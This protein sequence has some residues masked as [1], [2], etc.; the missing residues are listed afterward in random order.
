MTEI[1]PGL[2]KQSAPEIPSSCYSKGSKRSSVSSR[3]SARSHWLDSAA[4][5]AKL[6]VEADYLETLFDK[7]REMKQ[8]Q[9]QRDLAVSEAEERIFKSLEE[10]E[11]AGRMDNTLEKEKFSIPLFMPISTIPTEIEDERKPVTNALPI[12]QSKMS[13]LQ[14]LQIL[15]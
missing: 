13:H 14:Q 7:E 6:R 3:S 2:E 4:K 10:E 11:N 5:T 8:L 12:F 9:L 1:I 15:F